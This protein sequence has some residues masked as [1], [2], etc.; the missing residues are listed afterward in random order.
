VSPIAWLIVAVLLPTAAGYAL[1]ATVR[2]ARRLRAAR[3]QPTP[4]EPIEQ[5][6][7]RLRRLRAEVDQLEARPGG[8][9]R[10]HRLRAVRAAY[11]DVLS[12]ACD[13]LGVPPPQGGD[14]IEVARA[15]AALRS[16]G[17]DGRQGAP[18]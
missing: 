7:G 18:G 3:C 17:I 13:R 16:H 2:G 8:T 11:A 12:Q 4:A 9:A 15:E 5:L 1:I 6:A 10:S 14:R